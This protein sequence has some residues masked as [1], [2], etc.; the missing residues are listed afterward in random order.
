MFCRVSPIP[1][2]VMWA[3]RYHSVFLTICLE[4]CKDP[5]VDI[6]PDSIYFY[7]IGGTDK[8]AHELKIDLY[9]NVDPNVSIL[10]RVGF[11]STVRI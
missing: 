1:P 4:D 2:S 10:L 5:K 6:Q 8:K 7:G 3:Q 11:S 9:A